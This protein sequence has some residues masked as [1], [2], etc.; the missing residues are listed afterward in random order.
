MPKIYQRSKKNSIQAD[1]DEAFGP[2]T[3]KTIIYKM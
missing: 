3:V 1:M 2:N